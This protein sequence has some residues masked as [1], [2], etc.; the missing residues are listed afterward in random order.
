MAKAYNALCT[1]EFMVFDKTLE[2]QYH[3]QFDSARPSRDVPVTGLS[4]YKSATIRK[5]GYLLVAACPL[6]REI[7][8]WQ[9]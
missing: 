7:C 8:C 2:L 1:P 3:G 5:Q 6:L 4:L 9:Q